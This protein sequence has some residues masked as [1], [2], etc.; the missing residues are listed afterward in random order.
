MNY[1]IGNNLKRLR[2]SKNY[3]QEQAAQMLN[4]SPKSLSHWECGL[5]MPDIMRLPDIARLYGVT[6]D[7][8]F[9]EKPMAYENYA[10]RLLSVYETTHD[11]NDFYNA[12]REFSSLIKSQKYTMN[13][14]RSYAIL[15]QFHM[16]DCKNMALRLFQKGLDMG[17]NTDPDTY[18]QI[19]R[20]RML[21][22]SQIG[23]SSKV[24]DEQLEILHQNP[25]NFYSHLNLLVAYMMAYENQKALEV[26]LEAE[27]QFSDQAL[28]Y[29]YGGNLYKRL[30][31]YDLAFEC[32]DKSL[33][34][35]PEITDPL[36]AK[37]EC[38][39]ELGNYPAAHKV[40]LEIIA[41]LEARGFEVE[42]DEPRKHAKEC[43]EK[44]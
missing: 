11:A 23:E 39:E 14:L 17:V 6:I 5:T 9:R 29:A 27:K 44:M 22:L 16:L 24:I 4:I 33:E 40:W 10:I 30:K 2:L 32:W 28:L 1:H 19:E 3:T 25:H 13:D 8:L 20:Q 41:W 37:A 18:H 15:Y 43:K 34:L 42:L 26:F 12:D 7:D 35:D 36:W 31:T 21:M 38:Y